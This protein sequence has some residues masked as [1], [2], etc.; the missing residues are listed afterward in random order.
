MMPNRSAASIA[1]AAAL[2]ALGVAVPAS[3]ADSISYVKDGNVYLTNADGSETVQVTS[4]GGYS[5]ASQSDDGRILGL[6]GGRFHL[7]N[8]WGD[9]LAGLEGGLDVVDLTDMSAACGGVKA[10]VKVLLTARGSGNSTMP[11][12]A[13][14][15]GKVKV[16][17]LRP[18]N[19]PTMG[20]ALDRYDGR[21]DHGCGPLICHRPVAG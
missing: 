9:V 7:M 12:D 2:A 17:S 14:R 5:S 4:A 1:T 20:F 21:A 11:V 3:H 6:K 16:I 13:S 18:W 10:M 15:A 19:T 8:R